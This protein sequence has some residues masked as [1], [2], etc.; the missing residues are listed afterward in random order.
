MLSKPSFPKASQLMSTA[1][2]MFQ[3]V[4]GVSL[5]RRVQWPKGGKGRHGLGA[6]PQ[7]SNPVVIEALSGFGHIP[8]QRQFQPLA[9]L[10]TGFQKGYPRHS[11][12]WSFFG[13]P[14][15]RCFSR[16]PAQKANLGGSRRKTRPFTTNWT[17]FVRPKCAQKS[18]DPRLCTW[19]LELEPVYRL[20][21]QE[22]PVLIIH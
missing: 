16:T 22:T 2:H 4:A 8:K 15:W 13:T 3:A 5:K 12:V 7:K 10:N 19:F 14:P 11:G 17:P 21:E 18:V 1:S 9:F 6:N 20:K